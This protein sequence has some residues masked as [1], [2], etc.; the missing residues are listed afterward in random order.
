MWSLSIANL[1]IMTKEEGIQVFVIF[2]HIFF[3]ILMFGTF[4]DLP[5]FMDNL[6]SN[7]VSGDQNLSSSD[8]LNAFQMKALASSKQDVGKPYFW[9]QRLAGLSFDGPVRNSTGL[10]ANTDFVEQVFLTFK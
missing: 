5:C 7:L 4:S 2:L 1:L 3:V 6:L 10:Y 9:A 8:W